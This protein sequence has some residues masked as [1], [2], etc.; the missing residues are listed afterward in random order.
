MGEVTSTTLVGLITVDP[1]DSE[2]F[3]NALREVHDETKRLAELLFFD[4]SRSQESPGTF[5]LVEIWAKDLQY[6]QNVCLLYS[7]RASEYCNPR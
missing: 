4:L 2:T 6:L 1:A 7:S 5:H 3:L